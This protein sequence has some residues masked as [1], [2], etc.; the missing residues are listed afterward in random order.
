VADIAC[1]TG[2]SVNTVKS[3]LARGRSGLAAVLGD[4][5]PPTAVGGSDAH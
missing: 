1:E 2:A 5:A 4:L 3:W